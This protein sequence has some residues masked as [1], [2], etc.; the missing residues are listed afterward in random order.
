[1]SADRFATY[2]EAAANARR[3]ARAAGRDYGIE[4]LPSALEPGRP[5]R[6]WPLPRPE[7]RFGH[8]LRCEVVQPTDP[9]S[10]RDLELL[11]C[12]ACEGP[13]RDGACYQHGCPEAR[14]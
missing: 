1:M 7:N 14:S 6:I 10:T 4:R 2:E 12:P 13:L 3:A 5:F 8:E 11:A 9:Y